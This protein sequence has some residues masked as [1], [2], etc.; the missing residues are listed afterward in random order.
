[1]RPQRLF[2]NRK[3]WD[4]RWRILSPSPYLSN[5]EDGAP[6][7]SKDLHRETHSPT[8]RKPIR[9]P[10]SWVRF[11]AP[12]WLHSRCDAGLR[13]RLPSCA[14][15]ISSGRRQAAPGTVDRVAAPIGLSA[16]GVGLYELTRRKNDNNSIRRTPR[17]AMRSRLLSAMGARIF[18]EQLPPWC[19]SLRP[20]GEPLPARG[21]VLAS[22]R[23]ALQARRRRRCRS[24]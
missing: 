17:Q 6:R 24:R 11:R 2:A 7:R 15:T 14:P 18:V 1:M 8:S 21:S 16:I 9:R 12:R 22:S 4:R 23:K 19:H 5:R 13:P 3:T 10:L 20:S